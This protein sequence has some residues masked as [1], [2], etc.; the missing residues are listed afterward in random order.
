MR[1]NVGYKFVVY[2]TIERSR[3]LPRGFDIKTVYLTAYLGHDVIHI[4]LT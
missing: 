1:K 3:S 4:N 2:R